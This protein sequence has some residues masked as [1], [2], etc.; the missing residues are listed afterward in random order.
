[1][2]GRKEK[3]QDKNAK[4]CSA[5]TARERVSAPRP[6]RSRLALVGRGL[7]TLAGRAAGVRPELVDV[8]WDSGALVVGG[9]VLGVGGAATELDEPGARS[10]AAR[11]SR[12]AY[13]S[14]SRMVAILPRI[15]TYDG[16]RPERLDSDACSPGQSSFRV[17]PLDFTLTNILYRTTRQRPCRRRLNWCA[18]P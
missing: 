8:A 13:A 10:R 9:A 12:G 16:W 11:F 18:G 17:L 7:M 4:A 6:A 14:V 5:H 1:M 3:F 15:A 2:L